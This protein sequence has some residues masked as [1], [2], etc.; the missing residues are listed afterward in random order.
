MARVW[1]FSGYMPSN[2]RFFKMFSFYWMT[3][4]LVKKSEILKNDLILKMT[5]LL[6]KNIEIF[7]NDIIILG[8]LPTS[9]KYKDLS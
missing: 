5:Y 7:K 4:P 3:Y 9:E 1:F 6:V 8:D 2:Q